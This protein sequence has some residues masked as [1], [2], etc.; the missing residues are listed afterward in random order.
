MTKYSGKK[1]AVFAS[2]G[3][4]SWVV[5]RYLAEQGA[6]VVALLA[7][8]GQADGD[9][10]GHYVSDMQG[11]G[12]RIVRRDLRNEV[13]KLALD[14]IRHN[15]HYDGGYWNST[16]ALRYAL[17]TGFEKDASKHAVHFFSHGCVGGGNDQLR[18]HRYGAHFLRPA[19]E[20]VMWDQPDF[21]KRFPSRAAMVDYI[22]QTGNYK[23]LNTKID[24]S[25]DACLIGMSYEGSG[26][27]EPEFDFTTLS[28]KM[29]KWPWQAGNNFAELAISF[30]KG[31]AT[32][33]NGSRL[34]PLE[35]L[36]QLNALAGMHGVS[37]RSS[38]EN[39]IN[40]TKCR[41][42]YESPGMDVI[43]HAFQ[44][45]LSISIHSVD[46][47]RLEAAQSALGRLVYQ[48]KWNSA[49]ANRKRADS[50]VLL[51][52]INGTVKLRLYKGNICTTAIL[53]HARNN[54]VVF[55]KRFAGGGHVW[56]D[57]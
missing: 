1:I 52:K 16:G 50:D 30:E 17:V 40:S 28:P 4:V 19:L 6:R 33:V 22:S 34:R 39:R 56:G 11:L 43:A 20:L 14:M 55:Q 36:Q 25:T 21:K 54:K 44:S 37:L 49:L 47:K 18:F 41:G 31:L 7:D 48:G 32:H 29:S 10:I 9:W 51:N 3:L 46:R 45:L 42:I 8:V 26:F 5:S 12:V 57:Y 23:G 53:D 24:N 35:L 15:A 2:G 13:A 38:F 27:E